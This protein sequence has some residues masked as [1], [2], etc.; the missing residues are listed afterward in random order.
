MHNDKDAFIDRLRA[1]LERAQEETDRLPLSVPSPIRDR[2]FSHLMDEL[3]ED[4][5]HRSDHCEGCRGYALQM[6]LSALG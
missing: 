3:T 5:T 1:A 2:F 4:N 6:A